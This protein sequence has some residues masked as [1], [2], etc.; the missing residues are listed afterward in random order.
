MA[1]QTHQLAELLENEGAQ[2]T[3]VQTNAPYQPHWIGHIRGMRALFRLVPYVIGLWSAAGRVDVFHVMANSGWSWHF[4]AAPALRIARLRGV[5]TVVNYR[6]GQAASFITANRGVVRSLQRAQAVVVP[7]GFLREIFNQ[8][9]VASAVVPNIVDVGRFR[10]EAAS[11][12]SPRIVV[13]RNLEAIYDNATALRAFALARQQLPGLRITIAGSGPEERALRALAGELGIASAV[14][15]CGRV[16]HD[17]IAALYRGAAVALNPSRVDNMP[18]SVLEAMA[19]GVPVVSTD[20]GGVRYILRDGSTGLMVPAGNAAA[21]AAALLRVLQD[22]S[23]AS[24]LR[25]AALVEVQQYAWPKVR[26]R[27]A[28]VYRSLL[29]TDRARALTA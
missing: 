12:G 19:C 29:P 11:I 3:R 17:R 27:W 1:N 14:E 20:A 2:V 4:F 22:A 26:E 5:P 15:F 6:G 13:A 9:H 16:D 8:H 23:L 21:M 7:S 24:R 28:S 18:N 25:A 10:P